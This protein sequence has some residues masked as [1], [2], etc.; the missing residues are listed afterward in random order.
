VRDH[1]QAGY[2]SVATLLNCSPSEVA[3]VESATVAW[4]KAL[5]SVPL[6]KNDRILTTH[7][8]YG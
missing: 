4:Q 8:E 6:K 5:Y 1:L 3:M 2:Q 7:V